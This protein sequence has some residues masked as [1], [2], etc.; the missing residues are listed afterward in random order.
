[1]NGKGVGDYGLMILAKMGRR[2]GLNR[3]LVLLRWCSLEFGSGRVVMAKPT[4]AF[5]IVIAIPSLHS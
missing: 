5:S 2:K 1:M 3:L 4:T